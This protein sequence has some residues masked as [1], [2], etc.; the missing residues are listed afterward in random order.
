MIYTSW[1]GSI[2]HRHLYFIKFIEI[3]IEDV[4]NCNSACKSKQ[5]ISVKFCFQR[6][7]CIIMLSMSNFCNMLALKQ[8]TN[9]WT[10]FKKIKNTHGPYIS[11]GPFEQLNKWVQ[12]RVYQHVTRFSLI[13]K[14]VLLL[15]SWGWYVHNFHI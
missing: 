14:P 12:I 15:L 4:K 11:L 6:N 5:K 10:T 8:H 7:M 1:Y 2:C 3:L 9:S 13:V